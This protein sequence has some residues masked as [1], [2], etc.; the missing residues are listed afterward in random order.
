MTSVMRRRPPTATKPMPVP[1]AL[2]IAN[3]DPSEQDQYSDN[4]YSGP[5][6]LQVP[7][8]RSPART[9]SCLW[10]LAP[11]HSPAGFV[12]SNAFLGP[13]APV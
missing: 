11:L 5:S 8:K 9:R 13:E 3:R 10:L 7:R 1:G 4:S 6:H 2:V 12:Y